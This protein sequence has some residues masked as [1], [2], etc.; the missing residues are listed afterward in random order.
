MKRTR[1]AACTIL[2]L[3]IFAMLGVSA[4]AQSTDPMHALQPGGSLVITC[5]NALA[6]TPSADGKSVRLLCPSLVPTVTPTPLRTTTP[7]PTPTSLLPTVTPTPI[8]DHGSAEWHPPGG[9]GDIAAHEHGDA[10]PQWLLDAGYNPSFDHAANTPN[11]NS[12]PHK[13]TAM[14]GWSGKFG[15]KDA[16]VASDVDWY[17]IFHLDFN[18]GGHVSRLHSYQLWLRD[19]TSAVSH[20]HG[21]LDFGVGNST[22]PNVVITCG[23]GSAIRPIMKLNARLDA[24]G[25]PCSTLFETWYANDAS[26]GL[27][28]GLTISPN[29][30]ALESGGDP[31]DPATWKP[32]KIGVVNNMNRR[33]EFGIYDTT[34]GG[35]TGEFWTTQFGDDVSGATDPICDGLHTRQIGTKTYTVL[36]IEQTIQP[37]LPEVKFAT[38]NSVQRI[39]PT[40]GVRLV[41]PN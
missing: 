1:I 38:G 31:A 12:I 10:P 30:F 22:G 36:C 11:E 2:I 37:S 25:Q 7:G 5:P 3:T 27:D 21:W 4:Y 6:G 9:H 17:G 34:F 14:K 35:K 15:L 18:P 23:T 29:Y 41:L 26:P 8:H 16:S 28:I 33:I 32:V 20:M 24:N 39:F 40:G 19:S 13:H